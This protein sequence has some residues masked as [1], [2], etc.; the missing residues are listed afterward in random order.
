MI[1]KRGFY[2]I[3]TRRCG[4]AVSVRG[5]LCQDRGAGFRACRAGVGQGW[6]RVLSLMPWTLGLLEGDQMERNGEAAPET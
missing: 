4:V 6:A 3:E 2:K 1:A 5:S